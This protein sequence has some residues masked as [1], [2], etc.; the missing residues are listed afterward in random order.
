M[1]PVTQ[2]NLIWTIV[3]LAD[4]AIKV[5]ALFVVPRGRKPTAGM[6]WLLLIFLVP[7]VGLLLFLAIGNTKLSRE[8]MQRQD[9]T[10]ALI[11]SRERAELPVDARARWPE[12]FDGLVRQNETLGGIPIV[13]GNTVTLHGDYNAS[14]A[15]MA[16][17][18]DRAQSF[19]HVEFFIAARDDT[20]ACFFDAMAAAVARGVTVRLLLDYVASKRI[21]GHKEMLEELDRVGVSWAYLLP[22]RPLKGQYQ[23]I[24]LRNHRKL[25]VIDGVIAYTGSQNLVDRGYDSPSN[26]KRGLQWQ[27]LMARVEGPAVTSIHDV[28]RSDWLAE[29]GEDLWQSAGVEVDAVPAVLSERAVDC[30]IVPSGPSFAT[31]NNLRMF[32][33]LLNSARDRLVI[34]SP[35]FVPDEAVMYAIT[36]ACLRGV[37]VEL[38]VSEIGDQ[39]PVYHAQRSYY[40][41]LLDV[42]VRIFQYPAPYILHAKHLSVD[43]D[44]AYIGSSNMDIRSFALNFEISM[45]VRGEAF[46]ADMRAVE[47][48]YRAISRELTREEWDAQP[49]RARFL[50]GI[51]RLTSALE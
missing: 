13:A 32:L 5:I 25:V 8:R 29:T 20:T 49:R 23:R 11:R 37:A 42:G 40:G 51:A 22:V 41:A 43:E 44:V 50:D 24:D 1:D 18:I 35:Y 26:E 31:E 10:T 7:F 48:G 27:D 17:D 6:A 2:T 36:S 47:D 46:V 39:G 12:W 34:T 21:R 30:Q 15:T 28:F 45:L 3:V 16:A 19:V 38:F 4:A 14:I 33:A 9:Q